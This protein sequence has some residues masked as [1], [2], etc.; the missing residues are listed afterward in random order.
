MSQEFFP[1]NRVKLESDRDRKERDRD[2]TM[3]EVC[4]SFPSWMKPTRKEEKSLNEGLEKAS[5]NQDNMSR[6]S[7]LAFGIRIGRSPFRANLKLA[8]FVSLL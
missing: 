6:T 7:C 5:R 4:P 2:W 1:R 3:E 8:G